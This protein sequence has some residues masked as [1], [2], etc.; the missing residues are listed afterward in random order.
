MNQAVLDKDVRL[1]HPSNG[2]EVFGLLPEI[3]VHRGPRFAAGPI[4]LKYGV[5]HGPNHGFGFQHLWKAHFQL[6]LDHDEA[7]LEIRQH[8]ADCLSGPVTVFYQ[9]EPRIETVRFKVGNLILEQFN[10]PEP[11]YSVVSGGYIRGGK[12][13]QVGRINPQQTK[14]AP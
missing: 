11:H 3:L 7:L 5:H 14:K 13:S 12:G 4:Y 8:V 1:Q 9:A 6:T 2:S 10:R